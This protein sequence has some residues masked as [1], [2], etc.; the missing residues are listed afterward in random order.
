MKKCKVDYLQDE[1][2]C[3]TGMKNKNESKSFR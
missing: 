2:V 3:G 1:Y